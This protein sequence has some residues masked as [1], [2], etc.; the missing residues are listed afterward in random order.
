ME[1][2]VAVFG[3]SGRTGELVVEKALEADYEVVA[4]V[5]DREKLY[6]AS[7]G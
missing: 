1:M 6:H 2:K 4:F 5:R 7:D 3:A